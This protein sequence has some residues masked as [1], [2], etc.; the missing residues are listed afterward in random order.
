MSEAPVYEQAFACGRF[1]PPHNDH[2]EYLRAA[3]ATCRF[4]WVGIVRPDVRNMLPSVDAVHRQEFHANPL[5][6]FERVQILSRALMDSGIS[7]AEFAC[8]P[9]PLDEPDVLHAFMPP[10]VPCLTTNC[11]PWNQKKKEKLERAGYTVKVLFE[12]DPSRKL[13]GGKIREAIVRGDPS[14][15]SL[16]PQATRDAVYRLGLPERLRVLGLKP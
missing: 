9:F 5:T 12:R 4:L 3:K 13:E 16:V 14:W 1:Q 7:R 11:E 10:D 8:T 15:E 2:L 6:Y